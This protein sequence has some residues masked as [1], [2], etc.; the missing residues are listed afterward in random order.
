MSCSPF[1]LRDYVLAELGESERRSVEAHASACAA[2]RE[3][4]EQLRLTHSALLILRDEEVPQRIAFVSDKVFEPSPWR[5]AWGFVWTS[6][7]RLAFGAAAM[8]L[9]ASVVW[10]R[11][12][13]VVTAPA[14][15]VVDV[16][17]LR[18]DFDTRLQQEVAK[19]VASVEARQ[20]KR[21]G[22]LLQ[23]MEKQYEMNRVEL[24][25]ALDQSLKVMEGRRGTLI[26]ASGGG[27]GARQ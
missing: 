12:L 4:L 19:A 26:L 23:A 2:C 11:P 13:S 7:A 6:S 25:M 14:A 27:D 15:Q 16:A 21:D 1:D 22:D 24:Q 5:K 9:A 18:A 8:L 17:K 10:N 20:A 3:E